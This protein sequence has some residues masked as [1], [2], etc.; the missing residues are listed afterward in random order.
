MPQRG[1]T[2]GARTEVYVDIGTLHPVFYPMF[3]NG[4]PQRVETNQGDTTQAYLLIPH[5]FHQ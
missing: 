1:I 5:N 3:Y 2:I 4:N